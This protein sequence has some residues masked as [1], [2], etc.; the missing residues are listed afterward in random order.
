MFLNRTIYIENS[1]ENGWDGSWY[2]IIK[3]RFNHLKTQ[4][5]MNFFKKMLT[6]IVE[7]TGMA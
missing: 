6:V 3:L 2:Y 5:I 1:R 7:T 4:M